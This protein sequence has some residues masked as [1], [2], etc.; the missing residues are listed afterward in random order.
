MK[1]KGSK[2]EGLD[3]TPVDLVSLMRTVTRRGD[4]S[5][6]LSAWSILSKP[7][8]ELSATELRWLASRAIDEEVVSEAFRLAAEKRGMIPFPQGGN[9]LANWREVPLPPDFV[10]AAK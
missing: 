1:R 10:Q 7:E 3:Q 6:R 2:E 4:K 5:L 8:S 9:A